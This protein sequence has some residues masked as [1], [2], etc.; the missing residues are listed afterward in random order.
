M[1]R[2]IVVSNDDAVKQRLPGWENFYHVDGDFHF[3]LYETDG[4]KPIRLVGEDGGEPEDQTLGRDWKW[5]P[6]EMNK[7][8]RQIA[9]LQKLCAEMY[10]VYGTCGSSARVLDQ[11]SAAASGKPLPYPTLLPYTPE[12]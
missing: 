7:L 1:D 11:L 3:C 2:F 4:K 10:Q 9:Q 6:A 8:S 5:V 12:G